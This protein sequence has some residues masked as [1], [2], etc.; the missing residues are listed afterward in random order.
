MYHRETLETTNCSSRMMCLHVICKITFLS[1]TDGTER[2]GVGFVVG[3][4]L[5]VP[6][7]LVFDCETLAA[8]VASVWLLTGVSAQVMR[9]LLPSAKLLTAG[10]AVV[11]KVVRVSATMNVDRVGCGEG[12][13]AS[14][15]H[16]R[17]LSGVRSSV[18]VTRSF[19]GKTAGTDVTRVV[20]DLVVHTTQ[21][22]RQVR[23]R[24][25]LPPTD[26]TRER[27]FVSMYSYVPHKPSL[28]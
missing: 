26:V 12:F 20:L 9:Q 24:A 22:P 25:V 18:V 23:M 8:D 5:S 21:V 16:I 19:V 4:S 3:V 17:S 1:E 11:P 27:P 10:R 2:T 15:A 7:D 13:A 28:G 6:S 14:V